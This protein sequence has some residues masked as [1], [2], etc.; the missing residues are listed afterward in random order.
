MTGVELLREIR[1]L[2]PRLP[3]LLTSGYADAAARQ[4]ALEGI[5]VLPKPCDMPT[6]GRALDLAFDRSRRMIDERPLSSPCGVP[7]A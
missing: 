2:H 7:R 1:R 5:N 3:A 6:L 4:A